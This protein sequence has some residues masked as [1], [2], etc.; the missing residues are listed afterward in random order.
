M[1]IVRIVWGSPRPAKTGILKAGLMLRQFFTRKLPEQAPTRNQAG[2]NTFYRFSRR[3][4]CRS[5]SPFCLARRSVRGTTLVAAWNWAIFAWFCWESAAISCLFPLAPPLQDHLWYT[6][7]I[8]GLCPPISVLGAKR[9][10]SRAWTAFVILP[11][12]LVFAWPAG[13][14]WIHGVPSQRLQLETPM[15]LGYSLVLLMGYGNYLGTRNSLPSLLAALS[16]GWLVWQF[17]ESP[18]P[19]QTRQPIGPTL[20]FVSAV[21][22]GKFASARRREAGSGWDQIWR[23][24]QELYGIVWAKRIMDRVN[25]AAG[26]EQWSARLEISGLVWNPDPTAE[27]TEYT[28]K[29]LDHTFRW[30]LRRFVD[31]EWIERGRR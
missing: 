29:R 17:A 8:L 4:C 15:L 13:V 24:F 11:L 21:L 6:V 10:G 30:L 26:Q 3:L 1:L 2:W 19:A 23:D 7:A 20:L 28:M 25:L 5:F 22:I 18:P 14:E 31:P 27:Q 16:L 12:I 9:P